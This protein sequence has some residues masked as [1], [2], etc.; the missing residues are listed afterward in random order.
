[1]QEISLVG[2]RWGRPEDSNYSL[3]DLAFALQ[4]D[5]PRSYIYIMLHAYRDDAGAS[6]QP[7]ITS[8]I[9]HKE[10]SVALPACCV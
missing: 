9:T 1:M 6:Q 8:P 5:D 10:V 3:E 4:T 7:P 2:G